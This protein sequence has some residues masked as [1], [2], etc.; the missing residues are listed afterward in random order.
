MLPNDAAAC[1]RPGL[2]GVG[3]TALG[4]G[5]APLGNLYTTVTDSQAFAAVQR[6]WDLGVRYFDT[7]P[8]YGYGMSEDRL[9]RALS[10]MER[11]S[12]V[13]SSKV[14]RRIADTSETEPSADGFAV[15]GRRAT[16]DYSREG[17]RRSVESSLTRLKTDHIDILLLHDIG[18]LTHGAR[19]A[20][21]LRQALD[22]ALPE[23]SRL[24]AEGVC[25]AIG[26][27]VNEMDVC[28]EVMPLFPLDC[29]ML[30]GRYTLLEQSAGLE[31]L[32]AAVRHRVSVIVAAPYN[33]GLLSDARAPGDTYNYR[34]VDTA[35][36]V[37]AERIYAICA[38]LGIEV[39]A[40]ALQFPL[41]HRAVACVVAG[42][43]STAE[44]ESGVER[45]RAP[46]PQSLWRALRDAGLLLPEVP[47]P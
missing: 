4:F 39:G 13:L 37:R 19:H 20:Q 24:K 17:V 27:G 47:T 35:T 14:G 1:A 32:D 16:F 9:G 3:L 45:M 5:A 8:F 2:V 43:R 7:A 42:M 12:F 10:G 41:A 22:E 30:A 38:G 44:V 34:S 25:R 21:V 33:S 11:G 18:A 15:Q 23:M 29:I 6:A 26:I 40:A 46:I 31:V 36:R 28:L